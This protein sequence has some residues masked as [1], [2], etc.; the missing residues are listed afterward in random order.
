ME[1]ALVFLI[2]AVGLL[3]AL[4][5]A[6]MWNVNEMSK[7]IKDQ[8]PIIPGA[9]PTYVR[10]PAPPH[11]HTFEAKSEHEEQGKHVV[12]KVCWCGE[13]IREIG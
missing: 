5:L 6:G 10:A 8:K 1:F 2:I 12:V 3:F 9:T 7:K 4:V 11:T 13:V